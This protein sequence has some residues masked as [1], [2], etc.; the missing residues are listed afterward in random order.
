[1]TTIHDVRAFWNEQPLFTGES[2]FEP[3]T[4]EFFEHHRS[5]CRLDCFAGE[6]DPK[7]FARPGRE[8]RVLDLGCGIG[9]WLIEFW[10]R[11]F[12]NLTGA[13][14][15]PK[16]LEF[17][18]QRCSVYGASPKLR[19][20]NAEALSF[21]DG[22]FDHVNCQGVI[23]HTPN[24]DRAIEEIARVLVPGGTASISVYY[25]NLILRAWPL[26]HPV[27]RALSK[28]S[29]GLRGRGRDSIFAVGDTD[30]IVRWYDGK[31]NPIGKAYS[32]AVFQKMLAPHFDI[33]STYY[34]FFP[35]R[36]LADNAPMT[37]RKIADRVLPFMMYVS[38][39][40]RPASASAGTT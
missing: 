4:R 1:M 22:S 31:D 10:E 33:E 39:R 35:M 16:S 27:G 23:H 28:M 12:H 18:R 7:I 37:V 6:I 29:K 15:S 21:E 17:A 2:E 38:V 36:S 26:I 11:G 30:E 14:L 3:G 34:H 20:E 24:T 9:F 40:K 5:V 32:K 13:D 19:E 25:R 8:D